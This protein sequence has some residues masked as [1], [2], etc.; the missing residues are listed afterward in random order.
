VR[1]YSRRSSWPPV[2]PPSRSIAPRQRR[3]SSIYRYEVIQTINGTTRKGYRTEFDLEVKGGAEFAVVRATSELDN[4]AWKPVVPDAACRKAMNGT[5][6]SLARAQLYPMNPNGA[7]K[8]GSGFL[9]VCAPS[10]V[11][12][13]LTDILNVAM[14]PMPGT[15]H[16]SGLRAARESLTFP[17]FEAEYDRAGERLK[18]TSQGGEVRLAA[19]D[20]HYATFEW[21]PLPADL[22]LLER[23]MNPPMTMNGTE[24]WA[25]RVEVD[26]RSGWV[27]RAS[28][29]YDDLD[30][31]IVGA[32]DTVP[33]VR[34][35]RNVTIERE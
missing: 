33:H 13:P 15:F 10:A 31:K 32:P 19:V 12:F 4:G 25:F 34:I 21:R 22:T 6:N 26:R 20:D 16:A 35:A 29:L 17:G 1:C 9:D 2:L 27:D 7:Q 5:T 3:A 18:E 28:T 30:L 14:L 24:H 23:T 11:F 8:L